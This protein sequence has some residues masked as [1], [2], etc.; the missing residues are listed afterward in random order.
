M[1]KRRAED[2][3]ESVFGVRNVQNNPRVQQPSYSG[4]ATTAGASPWLGLVRAEPVNDRDGWHADHRRN[5]GHDWCRNRRAIPHPHEHSVRI[6]RCDGS[7]E[8]HHTGPSLPNRILCHGRSNEGW[9]T[10]RSWSVSPERPP[11]ARFAPMG[12]RR[13]GADNMTGKRAVPAKSRTAPFN[14]CAG[15]RIEESGAPLRRSE[16]R[17]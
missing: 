2:I 16:P 7:R 4:S 1:S 9:P 12:P 11:K 8:H 17:G 5:S 6:G 13:P 3:A 14:R 10:G 15:F